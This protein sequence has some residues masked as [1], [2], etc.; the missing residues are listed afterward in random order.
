MQ[1]EGHDEFAPEEPDEDVLVERDEVFGLDDAGEEV[2]GGCWEG[3]LC[4]RG[5]GG[6]GRHLRG[7]AA[8]G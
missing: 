6:V 5:L 2:W 4:M 1:V 3:R 7:G 8:W